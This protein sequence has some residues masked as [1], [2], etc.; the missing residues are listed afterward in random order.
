MTLDSLK[1]NTDHTFLIK[2]IRKKLAEMKQQ[3]G[4]LNSAGLKLT[5]GSRGTSWLTLAKEATTNADLID[6]Y[7]KIPKS[8]VMSEL[9]EISVETWQREWDLTTKG[10]ITKEYFPVV[11]DRL[12]MNINITPNLKTIITGHGNIRSYLHRFKIMD[13][14]ACACGSSDQTIDLMLYECALINQERD[15]LISAVVKT[16][17]WPTDKKHLIRK[18]YQPFVKFINKISFD[19]LINSLTTLIHSTS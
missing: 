6:S 19:K 7:K 1:N 8:V 15:S 12:S 17:V 16:D 5:S 2:E 18:H 4:H 11:A 14:P 3:I 13:T 9:S 10:A